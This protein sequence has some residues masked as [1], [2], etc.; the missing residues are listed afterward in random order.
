MHPARATIIL[1]PALVAQGIE[2]Q[3]PKLRVAGSIPAG[4]ACEGGGRKGEGGVKN[5]R[6]SNRHS[7]APR[8]LLPAAAKTVLYIR[9]KTCYIRARD[10]AALL[11]GKLFS[12]RFPRR[13]RSRCRCAPGVRRG[14]RAQAACRPVPPKLKSPG[15]LPHRRAT[16][17]SICRTDGK[18][19]GA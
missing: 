5:T 14:A 1:D 12:T 17:G 18:T 16:N 6:P 4:G 19:G 13:R 9:P 11:F 3:F 8:S 2:Q 10:I 15:V 7:L